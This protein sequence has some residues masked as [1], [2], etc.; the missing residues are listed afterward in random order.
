MRPLLPTLLAALTAL[1]GF[2]AVTEEARGQAV[3]PDLPGLPYQVVSGQ[4][5]LMDLWLGE[6][7]GPHPCVV[8]VHGGGWTS[9]SRALDR[10]FLAG[11][12]GSGITVASIDYRLTSQGA[13]FGEDEVVFPAQ[14]DDVQ[15]AIRF[16]RDH[17]VIL[18]LDVDRIGTWG[19]SA[20]AHLAAL[21][22]ARGRKN[23]P[24]G[25]SS[26]QATVAI[27]PPVDFFLMDDQADAQGCIGA[28]RH[29]EPESAESRLVGFD[30]PGEGIGVL[31]GLPGHPAHALVEQANPS[32]GLIG[33][34]PALFTI[35]GID[36]CVVATE[37]GRT[38]HEAWRTA[39]GIANLLI[40]DG[41][42][43][44]PVAVVQRSWEFF[45]DQLG[46]AGASALRIE[47]FAA[48]SLLPLDGEASPANDDNETIRQLLAP[49]GGYN[50]STTV[51]APGGV[52]HAVQ[53]D[54][55][56]AVSLDGGALLFH[57][58]ALSAGS[59]ATSRW[60]GT[61]DLG[62]AGMARMTVTKANAPGG[63]QVQLLV[64]DTVT[65]WSSEPFTVPETASSDAC[66]LV[67]VDLA[68]LAWAAVDPS[69][70]ATL[71]ADESDDGGEFGPFNLVGSWQP[72]WTRLLGF[73]VQ[74]PA[75]NP[76]NPGV[77]LAIDTLSLGPRRV[78]TAACSQTEANSTGAPG[79]LLAIGSLT[80]ADNGFALLASELPPGQ[81]VYF[82]A[83]ESP[84]N[85]PNPGGAVGTL[86]LGP[87][88]LR[89]TSTLGL[90]D[91]TGRHA[92][93]VDLGEPPL[94]S[95]AAAQVGR[96]LRFQAW[97]R[98]PLGGP[99]GSGFTDAVR[100]TFE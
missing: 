41:A 69:H 62:V 32:L 42:H 53:V 28:P 74:I 35:H 33:S 100:V 8:Y 56:P 87:A 39:G 26:V 48:G 78:G 95:S 16:L 98:E 79:Q 75:G 90:V 37:Q 96:T 77:M 27:S 43:G 61:L 72:D 15:A 34:L 4:N 21:A 5:L 46:P 58:G 88:I 85:I 54:P 36:D 66:R 29:D 19:H 38:L 65:W 52:A 40:H 49:W 86:C 23:D 22:A 70:P 93:H 68:G 20:G 44:I 76:T 99:F 10:P 6:G 91:A 81:P 80:A 47:D 97:H 55:H 45:V 18:D 31:E 82:L 25:D 24:L 63:I 64:R 17:A 59:R 92:A 89:I 57:A 9:G 3:G 71:D 11:L 30:G 60:E 84:A 1:C 12:L 14:L 67:T 7:P 83:S 73:G 94:G 50:A 2:T 51:S 13:L